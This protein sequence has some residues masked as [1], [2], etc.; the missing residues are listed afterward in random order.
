MEKKRSLFILLVGAIVFALTMV[1]EVTANRFEEEQWVD[2]FSGRLHIVE[3]QAKQYLTDVISGKVSFAIDQENDD[4]IYLVFKSGRLT[5]WSNK[6]VG[7]PA[8]YTQ[9]TSPRPIAKINGVYYEK[10]PKW[11][12]NQKKLRA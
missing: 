10:G 7:N 12:K 6:K 11:M 8:L 9:I 3:R 5:D 2:T 1:W 4:V